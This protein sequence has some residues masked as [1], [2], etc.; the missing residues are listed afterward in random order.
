ME[1]ATLALREELTKARPLLPPRVRP[2]RPALRPRG[3]PRPALPRVHGLG[4]LRPPGA[5]GAGQGEARDRPGLGPGRLGRRGRRRLGAGD[6][7]HPRRGPDQGPRPP[8][9]HGQRGHRRPARDLSRRGGSGAATRS[10]CS[11]SPTASTASTSSGETIVAHS[12]ENP[13]LVKDVAKVEVTYA[14]IRQIHRINGQPTVS[15]TVSKER[16]ANTLRVAADVKRKL[17]AIKRELPPDL[18]FKS[19]DDESEEIRKNLNDLYLLAGLITVI[20]FVMI[21]VVL[22]RFKPSLL[23][24]SSIAFSIVITFNLIYVFRISLNML[25]LGALALGFGMFVDNSI[26]VFENILRLRESGMEAR[27]AAIQGPKEVFVAVLASTLTTMAVFFSFPFFQGKLKIYYLPLAIVIA[28]AMAA[29]LLVSFTLIPA[30]SP[31]L[32]KRTKRATAGER[33]SPRFEKALGVAHP[34]SRRGPARRRGAPLRGLQMVPG[35]GDDRPLVSLVLEG[36]PLRPG[37]H[38]ARDRHRPDRRDHPRLRREG[39]GPG[40]REGDERPHRPG[41]RPGHH[42]LPAGDRE[43]LP[44]L[45]P[46]GGAHPAGH[47]VRRHRHQRLGLRSAILLLE[48]GRGHLLQLAD[49][50]LRLQPQEAQGDHGRPRKD[51]PPQ[52]AH[53][54]GPDG[55]QP[56]RLVAGRHGRGHP[57]DRQGRAQA[58]RRRPGLPLLQ[59]PD[60]DPGDL[61]PAGPDP[62]GGQ[63]HHRLGQVPRCGDARHARPQRSPHP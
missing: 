16:G 41:E 9:L 63:G 43:V 57:Q 48:H 46:Q 8:S 26:V 4:R 58:L 59:P 17:E 23:I 34:P 36:V 3:L 28:S 20:V 47:P 44:A 11:S 32:L 53:Q 30:L 56:L 10:S 62:D 27:E 2:V 55:L 33:R 61:R 52:S 50:V 5:P 6:P 51:P 31:R 39:H 45:R 40:L 19:V 21:F 15:L 54:G 14:D 38:A 24:L 49:Q 29:S 25:T 22:R 1:F 37:R 7:G 42:R 35:R 13:I 60:D 18:V 12:G